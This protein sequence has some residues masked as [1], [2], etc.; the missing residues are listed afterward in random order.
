MIGLEKQ[1][2]VF[3]LS[4]SLRPVLPY[5]NSVVV[6]C[7]LCL[8]LVMPWVGLQSMIVAFYGHFHFLD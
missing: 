7:V 1:F 4:G 8:F 6:A 2:L 3:F 5:F